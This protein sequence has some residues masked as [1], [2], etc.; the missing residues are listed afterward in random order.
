MSSRKKLNRRLRWQEKMRDVFD[1]PLE[2]VSRWNAIQIVGNCEVCITGCAG[3]LVYMPDRILLRGVSGNI[4]ILG[5][6]LEMNSLCGD[7]ATV[8]GRIDSVY[9]GW[10]LEEH[11]W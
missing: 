1:V 8:C 11:E 7:R 9:P 2:G 5:E 10:T 3:V 4:L 6:H